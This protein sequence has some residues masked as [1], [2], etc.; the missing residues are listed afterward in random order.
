MISA[1]STFPYYRDAPH[2]SL[3]GTFRATAIASRCT[4]SAFRVRL[5]HS[6]RCF[7]P[8]LATRRRTPVH[9]YYKHFRSPPT[10]IGVGGRG[11]G[12]SLSSLHSAGILGDGAATSPL[13]RRVIRCRNL[14]WISRWIIALYWNCTPFPQSM[15]PTSTPLA[16]VRLPRSFALLRVRYWVGELRNGVVTDSGETHCFTYRITFGIKRNRLVFI[17]DWF[18]KYSRNVAQIGRVSLKVGGVGGRTPY[19][20]GGVWYYSD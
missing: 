16:S 4:P 7:F 19:T 11:V 20:W 6:V 18:L 9:H 10:L 13:P 3:I 8:Y 5:A 2:P 15:S 1:I 14:I 17:D 12:P